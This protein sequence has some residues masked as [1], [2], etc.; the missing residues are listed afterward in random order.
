MWRSGVILSVIESGNEFMIWEILVCTQIGCMWLFETYWVHHGILKREV[1]KRT[2]SHKGRMKVFTKARWLQMII[3]KSKTIFLFPK[4]QQGEICIGRV[5]IW[6]PLKA[7]RQVRRIWKRI[8]TVITSPA[9]ALKALP[10]TR[11]SPDF[12]AFEIPLH[13]SSTFSRI[14]GSNFEMLRLENIGLSGTR[15]MAWSALCAVVKVLDSLPNLP[16]I[17][18][19]LS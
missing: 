6:A 1:P 13:K 11:T 7:V 14:T 9:N 12:F 16:D 18:S 8:L 10:M 3:R 2:H 15:R 5:N 4:G 17:H 19:Y